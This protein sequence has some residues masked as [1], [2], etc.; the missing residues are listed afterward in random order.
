MERRA[1]DV[2][3]MSDLHLG[4]YGCHAREIVNYLKS[5]Q[6]QILV[7]NGDV[8]DG[9]QFSKRYFPV[10]HMQ[11][12]KEI[13]SLLGKGTRVI[14]I[15]GNHDEV[16]RRYS[17]I[18]IGN[19]QLTDKV[20]MEIN[21][22]MTWIFHGDVFDATTKGG[23]KI[24]AKLGGHGYDLLIVMNRCINWFLKL[25]GREKM[26]FSKRVKNGVKKAV[27][28]IGDFE[29]TA[30]EL[31]IR[32]QYDY[33]IC[34]HIHQPQNRVI[35]TKDGSVTYLNSGDWVENLTSLEYSHNEW[36]IYQYNEKEYAAASVVDMERK[37]P[38]LNVVTDKVAMSYPL[39]LNG[40][41]EDV[42]FIF[43]KLLKFPLG[44]I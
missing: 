6:P 16:L 5:I 17:D 7:L 35:E 23:A 22:K 33:V 18:E 21:G 38:A 39:P 32:K 4:T 2:V 11:V 14:Y 10:A 40:S 15:T 42:S 30:A 37:L 9:W 8:I 12:I 25:I 31:A 3:V 29:Q 27:S 24:L 36:K 26:S 19:F 41:M 13:M 44:R 20:V 28:W 34:G 43:E 1:L